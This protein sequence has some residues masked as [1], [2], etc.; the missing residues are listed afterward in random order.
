MKPND[1]E[2]RFIR[3]KLLSMLCI[4]DTYE[5][6]YDH[7][8]TAVEAMPDEIPF[9]PAFHYV[10]EHELGGKR[11]MRALQLRS[12]KMAIRDAFKDYGLYFIHSLKSV[13]MLLIIT[14]TAVFYYLVKSAYL[15]PNS[16]VWCDYLMIIPTILL[17]RKRNKSRNWKIPKTEYAMSYVKSYAA[18]LMIPFPWLCWELISS[19]CQHLQTAGVIEWLPGYSLKTATNV[20]ATN[21][22]T[23]FF[24]VTA[25]NALTFYKLYEDFSKQIIAQA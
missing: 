13:Y 16:V 1:K 10:F 20:A 11:G 22:A 25:L 15:T 3:T 24:F 21:I 19:V 9:R 8:L 6:L 4:R 5:E 12:L 17:V 23:A 18:S 14:T 7:I 2:R